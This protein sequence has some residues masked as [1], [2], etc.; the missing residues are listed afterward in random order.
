MERVLG[1][2]PGEARVGLAISD[3]LGMLAHPLETITVTKTP[4]VPRILAIAKERGVRTI[5]VGIARN[6]DGSH[7]ASSAKGKA[8]VDALREAGAT[9][10]IPWDER[11]STVQAERSLRAAGHRAKKQRQMIDQAAAQV[12]LQSWLDSQ[13]CV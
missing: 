1:I 13:A 9:S 11:L 3:E 6:M 12:I 10:V 4:P 7:G 5:V 8:L 2:D